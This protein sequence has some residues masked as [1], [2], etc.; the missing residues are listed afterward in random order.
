MRNA[1]VFRTSLWCV[2]GFGGLLRAAKR[3][4]NGRTKL[5]NRFRP[6]RIDEPVR[7][8]SRFNFFPLFP[9]FPPF[10]ACSHLVRKEE[11]SAAN[12]CFLKVKQIE[13]ARTVWRRC[14]LPAGKKLDFP[15]C[16]TSTLFHVFLH[17]RVG[18]EM[19]PMEQKILHTGF[20]PHRK[21][22]RCIEC[23]QQFITIMAKLTTRKISERL[24][25]VFSP[26]S[27]VFPF[28]SSVWPGINGL[29]IFHEIRFIVSALF[30]NAT[31]SHKSKQIKF[32][33]WGIEST[34]ITFPSAQ[35]ARFSHLKKC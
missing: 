23:S 35:H 14:Y 6:T 8:S 12:D 29:A 31:E 24:K 18:C 20:S 34:L 7:P 15:R 21:S 9:R 26:F 22:V 2:S 11:K 33:L 4:G 19:H 1:N 13:R 32:A 5:I 27:V 16:L 28:A 25:A 30:I 10:W 3:N 17:I